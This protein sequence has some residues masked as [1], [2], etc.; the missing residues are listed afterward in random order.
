MCGFD[1]D[2]EFNWIRMPPIDGIRRKTVVDPVPTPTHL[3]CCLA[4]SKKNFE[5]LGKYDP[6]LEIWGCEN[7]ELSFKAW[8]CG[9]RLEIIPCAHI[10]HMFKTYLPFKF[11]GRPDAV[12]R[13][14]L[15]VAEVWMDQYKVFYEH[16]LSGLEVSYL[17]VSASLYLSL[18]FCLSECVSMCLFLFFFFF[19]FFFFWFWFLFPS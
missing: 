16:R 17:C 6:G 19:F 13:N 18:H 9:S 12:R 2:M 15:R 5:K 11:V 7:L 14:C 4:T 3:G 10:G 1:F 8:M